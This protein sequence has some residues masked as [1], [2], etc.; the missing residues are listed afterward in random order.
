MRRLHK[1]WASPLR[2]KRLLAE[3][4][5]RLWVLTIFRLLPLPDRAQ[6]LMRPHRVSQRRRAAPS[7][8][9]MCRAVDIAARFVPGATCLVKA[10]VCSAML[11]H[12]GYPAEIKI[13]VWKKSS[14]LEAHAWVECEGL[15]VLGASNNQYVELP[16]I[17]APPE[18]LSCHERDSFQIPCLLSPER[19][20]KPKL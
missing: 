20:S 14:N 8:E 1:L 11:N 3:A 9:E 17:A 4:L 6:W 12:L 2:F 15:V 19:S 5:V 13:G 16:K 18:A 10:Q 7:S